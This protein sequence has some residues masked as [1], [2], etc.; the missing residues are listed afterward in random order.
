MQPGDWVTLGAAV[1][2]VVALTWTRG[3]ARSAGKPRPDEVPLH[4]RV[5]ELFGVSEA[6]VRKRINDKSWS[7]RRDGRQVR[8]RP[9]KIAAINDWG[10]G[11]SPG[12]RLTRLERR[13]RNRGNTIAPGQPLP[14]DKGH[15]RECRPGWLRLE[16]TGCKAHTAN[17]EKGAIHGRL[18]L[19]QD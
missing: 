9:E 12:T 13:Q 7:A 14:P 1:L 11:P 4:R 2:A 18:H 5:A 3:Q 6:T 19:F 8:F 10:G 17:D 15:W 16:R